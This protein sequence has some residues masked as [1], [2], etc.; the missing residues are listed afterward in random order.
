MQGLD[1]LRDVRLKIHLEEKKTVFGLIFACIEFVIDW[2][3]P[4][5]K[6]TKDIIGTQIKPI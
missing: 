6:E 5:K 3:T 1:Y 2:I 4:L